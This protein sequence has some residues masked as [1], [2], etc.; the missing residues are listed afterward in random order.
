MQAFKR[1]SINNAPPVAQLS[2]SSMEHCALSAAAAAV[3]AAMKS[4]SPPAPE[5]RPGPRNPRCPCGVSSRMRWSCASWARL[6]SPTSSEV[7]GASS[8]PQPPWREGGRLHFLLLRRPL[9]ACALWH[10]HPHQHGVPWP[11]TARNGCGSASSTSSPQATCGATPSGRP[12]EGRV[13]IM[14]CVISRSGK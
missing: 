12:R 7:F 5:L 14:V 4:P 2:P 11:N 9:L 3:A 6:Q 8:Q 13:G 10:P 1:Q